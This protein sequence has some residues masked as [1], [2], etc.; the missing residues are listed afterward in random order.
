[1]DINVCQLVPSLYSESMQLKI[2][3]L[4]EQIRKWCE[5]NGI[6]IINPEPAFRL[7]TGEIDESCYEIPGEYQGTLLNRLDATKL[8]S[9]IG[10][11]CD[12]LKACV[13]WD[14]VR[15]SA[16]LFKISERQ[17]TALPP[18]RPPHPIHRGQV[19]DGWQVVDS[20][21]GKTG[22]GRSHQFAVTSNH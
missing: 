22:H 3:D 16:D 20:R 1:M 13:N 4:S 2:C 14:N 11:Q 7:G 21:R 15:S 9:V 19:R 10:K 17:H 5:V 8:L 18:P 6:S 12:K